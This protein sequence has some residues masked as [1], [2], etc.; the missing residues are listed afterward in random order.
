[1][2][3][4]H[5]P[6]A[7]TRLLAP[8]LT[9]GLIAGLTLTALACRADAAAGSDL[10]RAPQ[11][12]GPVVVELFTSQGC[13]SCPPA[14]RLLTRLGEDPKLDRRVFPLAFHVD[15]WNY[16]GWTDPFSSERW[17]E[18]QRSYARSFGSSRV[19]TPQLVV[20][21]RTE[22]VGSEQNEVYQLIHQ[23]LSRPPLGR[24]DLRLAP[25]ADPNQL[26][27]LADARLT[28]D[29]PGPLELW[30]ALY[31]K[32]LTTGVARGE[33][34]HRTLHNDYVVRRLVKAFGLGA[35]GGS[36]GSGAVDLELEPSWPRND[37]GVVA[38][39]QDP[40]TRV[41]HGAARA[42]LEITP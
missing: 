26:R 29:A 10:E 41:I 8:A 30:V 23:A 9:A 19:Y 17:S 16:I 22:C 14:D 31:Q 5:R 6:A 28:A 27:A 37:L 38:F 25:G 34:A 4:S 40:S 13:S 24:V 42:S 21:G 39:L 35:A 32:D 1:M 18:R 3:R 2:S 20:D 7:T 33:N 12:A 15:Y 36:E 11:G